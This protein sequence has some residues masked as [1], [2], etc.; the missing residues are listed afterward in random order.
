MNESAYLNRLKAEQQK[1]ALDALLRP[2]N[3]DGFEYGHR[4]GYIA[5]M[6]AAI[7]MLLQLLKDERNDEPTL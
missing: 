5:G 1:F 6:E 3:R 4:C 2:T 7:N